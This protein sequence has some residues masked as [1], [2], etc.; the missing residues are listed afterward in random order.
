MSFRENRWGGLVAQGIGTSMLQMGNIVRNAAHLDPADAGV[1]RHRPGGDLHFPSAD[2]RCG[3][4]L[5][6]G[7]LRPCRPASASTPA[8]S[9][10]SPPGRRRPSP[11]MDWLGLV[12]VSLRAAGGANVAVRDPPAQ[13]GLDQGGRPEAR[14]LRHQKEMRGAYFLLMR[15]FASLCASAG[16]WP[17]CD[18]HCAQ[19]ISLT[20]M[21]PEK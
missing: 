21:S 11:A 16:R 3:R 1:G 4:L 9:M 18:A 12:L 19:G 20:R 7:H 8:G 6:H 14:P 5:R 2:E 17:A 10:T 15:G 13:V